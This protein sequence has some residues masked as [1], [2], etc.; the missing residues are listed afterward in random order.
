MD[1]MKRRSV[2]G[3][4]IAIAIG[5]LVTWALSDGSQV[6]GSVAVFAIC[7]ALAYVV[8]W[9]AFVPAYARQ[10]EKFYDLTGSITY[11]T[12][13]VA[14]LTLSG[15]LDTR[16]WVVG[17]MVVV[18]TVRLGTF[19]FRRISRDGGDGRFDEI[20]TDALRFFMT[21]T[22]QALWVLFTAAAA[23]TIITGTDRV[24]LGWVGYL[25]IA[26]WVFGFAIEVIA[27]RQKS[28]FKA[29]PANK[30]AFITTGLWSWSRHPNYFGEIVLW[31]GVAILAV[32]VLEGWRWVALIS[33]LFVFVLITRVSGVPMLE[34]RGKD[35]WG[36]DP[37]Y[38]AY[39][40]RTSELVLL[41]PKR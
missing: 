38:Q 30:G 28:A 35:R 21:W 17:A 12:V 10:T 36:D 39:L 31:L 37:A 9:V 8:N 4:A 19:L 40:D 16:S 32:P 24:A 1:E 18:W 5:A 33:P 11:L 6:V 3:T 23:L 22:I 15:D 41:P 34:R 29:D 13:V 14:A 26:V 25:G 27:D 7:A 2:I 20:K